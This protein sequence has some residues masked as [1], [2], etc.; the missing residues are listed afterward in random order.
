MFQIHAMRTA[1]AVLFGFLLLIPGQIVAQDECV[2][3]MLIQKTVYDQTPVTMTRQVNETVYQKQKVTEYK[4][5]YQTEKRERRTTV[6]KPVHETSERIE[7]YRVRWPVTETKYRERQYE[8]TVYETVTEMQ[9]QQVVVEEPVYETQTREERVV[10]K[11]PV[12]EQLIRHDTTTVYRPTLVEGT[13]LTMANMQV[14]QLVPT[15]GTR[16]RVQWL[17]PGYYSD[18]L[19]GQ[20]VFR[21]RGLH[22]VA[23]PPGFQLQSTN[24]PVLA[25][26]PSSELALVPSTVETRTPV[27]VTR[28]VEAV[29][30]RKVPVQVEKT[31]RRI[32][33][34][35]VPV[36]VK[37]PKI[38]VRTEQI[39]YEV[40]RY[41]EQII[42]QKVPVSKTTYQ[43]VERVEPYEVTV[44][45]WM[46][47]TREIEVPKVVPKTV[48]VAMI[49]HTPRTITMKV[50]IDA[51]GNIIGPAIP[52]AGQKF[53]T[54]VSSPTPWQTFPQSTTT[55]GLEETSSRKE[56]SVVEP[57]EI[58]STDASDENSVREYRARP[59]PA[60]PDGSSSD[61]DSQRLLKPT[62]ELKPV[63][64]RPNSSAGDDPAAKTN[65]TDIE[66]GNIEKPKRTADD[67]EFDAAETPALKSPPP[68]IGPEIQGP[69]GQNQAQQDLG[70]ADQ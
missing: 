54:V 48:E 10:V 21:R 41:I 8:E 6:L 32:E 30:T 49:K 56:F 69:G 27:D 43:E 12:T 66:P 11:R 5:V 24:V 58:K 2:G 57:M 23:D 25:T 67:I 59:V 4:P 50:P 70:P 60:E 19:T 13:E 15:F 22:W 36:Q 53:E 52:L 37:K 55:N 44:S 46:P 40:T 61:A 45:N 26:Q 65:N 1:G 3:Y 9:E 31:V 18:P 33:T 62:T 47:I 51:F 17:A 63:T 28:Y 16:A 35:K 34:R 29:E 38:V 42:E 14:D 68:S 20:T 7:R 64:P 39:P